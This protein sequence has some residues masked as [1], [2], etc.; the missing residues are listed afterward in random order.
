MIDDDPVGLVAV[1]IPT[2][3]QKSYEQFC[4]AWKELFHKHGVILITV[5]DGEP[6]KQRVEVTGYT[7]IAA[8]CWDNI[9]VD[10]LLGDD[11]DLIYHKTDGCRNA[12]F[13]Y[14]AKNL[15]KG[16]EYIITLDD[17]LVPIGDPIQE[18]LDQLHRRVPISWLSTASD[19]VYLR[20]FPYGIR[21]EAP[22]M[23]SHGIWK[24][25]PDFD[26]ATQLQMPSPYVDIEM[27]KGPIPKGA[28]L[29]LCGMN[30]AFRREVLP[31]VYYAPAG[32]RTT[33]G[34]R[35]S[36]MYLGV[37]LKEAC[38]HHS[39]AIVTGYAPVQH[40]RASNV[41]ENLK[42]EALG[43]ELNERLWQRPAGEHPEWDAYMQEYD[44]ARVRWKTFMEARR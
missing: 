30:L 32:P 35:F 29:A 15:G 2:I 11:R 43:I 14:L 22:V 31:Y 9:R 44:A 40:D 8:T 42:Q 6:N 21:Q 18:H 41:W 12:G 37:N 26:A 10:D 33:V 24:G 39:W 20:G 36:D 23:V 17:D 4:A 13:W 27:Y 25:V 19:G 5:F 34:R 28:Y 16:I 3:R 1:V 38:D 7:D